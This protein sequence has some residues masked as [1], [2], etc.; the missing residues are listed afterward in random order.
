MSPAERAAWSE[1]A[2]ALPALSVALLSMRGAVTC[3]HGAAEALAH[4]REGDMPDQ[5]QAGA[6]LVS[7]ACLFER[8]GIPT[9]EVAP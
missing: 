2:T 3:A 6:A 1:L 9:A 8:L 5:A 4:A 7:V